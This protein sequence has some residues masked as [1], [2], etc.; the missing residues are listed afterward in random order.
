MKGAS[1]HFSVGFSSPYYCLGHMCI[2]IFSC[3][4]VMLCSIGL[5]CIGG[6]SHQFWAA[7]VFLRLISIPTFEHFKKSKYQDIFLLFSD[8]RSIKKISLKFVIYS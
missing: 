5:A 1:T 6:A 7:I 2:M 8:A 4:L 3:R